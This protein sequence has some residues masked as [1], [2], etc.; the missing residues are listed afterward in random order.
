MSNA[1]Y[2]Q[3]GVVMAKPEKVR[4]LLDGKVI[5]ETILQEA[6]S[7]NGNKRVYPKTVINEGLIAIKKKIQDRGFLGELDHP[8]PDGNNSSTD[9]IRQ[10]TVLYKN[11][12]H[13]ISDVWW[14]GI[15]LKGRVETLPY[16]QYGRTLSGLALDN[17]PVGF[18]L[19]GLAD[20]K[21]KGSFQEVVGPLMIICYDSV[22]QP[23]NAKATIQEIKNENLVRI[24]HESLNSNIYTLSNGQR[25]TGN[26]LDEAIE[27]RILKLI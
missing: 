11:V 5:F 23:S 16:T 8:I 22:S 3:E 13:V 27:K 1:K 7:V 15:L 18:S 19:R 21:D 25:W 6:D 20:V 26:A 17:I 12:S 4:K 10:T 9:Q 24:V 14:D 2:I